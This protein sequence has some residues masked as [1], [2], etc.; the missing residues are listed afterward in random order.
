VSQKSVVFQKPPRGASEGIYIDH[1][2]E[3]GS[4]ELFGKELPG[5]W[6]TYNGAIV[7]NT[8][9]YMRSKSPFENGYW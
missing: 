5:P 3:F 2:F 1:H 7:Y 8:N 9:L 4:S 6:L